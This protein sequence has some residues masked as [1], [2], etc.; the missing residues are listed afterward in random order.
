MAT[1]RSRAKREPIEERQDPLFA[2]C[3]PTGIS[4]ADTRVERHGDYKR[5]A[6]LSYRTLELDIEKD[7]SPDLRERIIAD[8][9]RIKARRGEQYR[10]STFGQTVT[11]GQ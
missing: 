1:E 5:C 7:C 4:Y 3:F 6:F 8:A 11:L 10:I 9:A 2:G